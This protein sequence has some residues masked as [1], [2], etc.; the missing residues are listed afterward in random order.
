MKTNQATNKRSVQKIDVSNK[1]QAAD[2]KIEFQERMQWAMVLIHPKI[3]I[4]T[5]PVYSKI[6][7]Q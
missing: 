4:L 2:I 5:A 6:V 1:V 7:T 3:C